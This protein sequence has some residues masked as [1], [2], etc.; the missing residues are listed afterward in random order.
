MAS[1]SVI[2]DYVTGL[3]RSLRGPWRVKRDL[4]AEARDGLVDATEA[5]EADGLPRSEAERLAVEEF[6][7]IGE[8][9]PAYQEELAVGQGRRTA[10]L[11]FLSVPLTTL[12]WSVIWQNYPA[13]P[14]AAM[15]QWPGWFGPV[16][17]V[18]D[19]SGIAVGLLGAVALVVVGPARRR[20]RRP[21][22]V[23]R[24]LGVLIWVKVPVVGVLSFLLSSASAIDVTV[25]APGVVATLLT[26][27]VTL[28]QLHSGTRCLM[29]SSRVSG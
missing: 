9:A 24:A 26:G 2:D 12:M 13:D 18:V 4:M 11:L 5:L 3:A 28:W 7:A 25:Y 10:L 17:R 6:G 1:A 8:I 20:V 16:S 27:A 23:T 22:L 21:L 14:A 15:A 19:Y 29:A